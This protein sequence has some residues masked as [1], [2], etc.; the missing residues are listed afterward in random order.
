MLLPQRKMA[1]VTAGARGGRQRANCPRQSRA[2]VAAGVAAMRLVLGRTMRRPPRWRP[3]LLPKR[4]RQ[5]L[6]VTGA[7]YTLRGRTRAR[8]G[9]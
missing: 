8:V 2:P 3:S 5:R 9:N 1:I 7:A 4:V 6:A